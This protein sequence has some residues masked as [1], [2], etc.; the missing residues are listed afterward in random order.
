M[1]DRVDMYEEADN[2]DLVDKSGYI[3]IFY[4]EKR[5]LAPISEAE[6]L[7][8]I[9]KD[10]K[11]FQIMKVIKEIDRDNNGYVTNQE[12]DDIFKVHYEIELGYRDL[13]PVFKRFASM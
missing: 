3:G 11:L 1:Y 6:L 8:I 4:R 13:K 5:T 7:E 12:L 2:P 9:I 10:N